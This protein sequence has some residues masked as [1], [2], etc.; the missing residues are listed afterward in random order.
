MCLSIIVCS[1]EE[2]GVESTLTTMTIFAQG[3]CGEKQIRVR[4]WDHGYSVKCMAFKTPK[5]L[6]G[7]PF[8]RELYLDDLKRFCDGCEKCGVGNKTP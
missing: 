5:T 1:S 2:N 7:R 3:K 6:V 8:D 4:I